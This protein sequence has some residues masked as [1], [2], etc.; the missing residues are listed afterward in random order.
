MSTM[1][2]FRAHQGVARRAA[3]LLLV[4]ALLGGAAASLADA[5]RL[6]KATLDKVKAATAYLQVRL[7]DGSVSQGS[8]FFTFEPG[9]VITNAHVLGMLEANCRPPRQIAVI[10]NSGRPDSQ[11]LKARL[12]GVDR[13]SDLAGL[14]VDGKKLAKPV[15]VGT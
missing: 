8:G 3:G 10:V 9:L 12:L 15:Q 6:D 5:P 7:P 13:G 1:P 4:V 14:R 2:T 11:T